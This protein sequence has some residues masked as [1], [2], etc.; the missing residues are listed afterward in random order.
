[1]EAFFLYWVKGL[2]FQ[3]VVLE[4]A[5]RRYGIKILRLPHFQVPWLLGSQLLSEYRANY[6]EFPSISMRDLQDHVRR[7]FGMHWIATGEKAND[8]FTRRFMM[9]ALKQQWDWK[10]GIWYPLYDWNN[11]QV[12]VYMRLNRIAMPPEY[13]FMKDSWGSMRGQ[14]LTV[15]RQHFP[16]DYRRVLEVFP[17]AEAIERNHEFFNKGKFGRKTKIKD[18]AAEV[19]DG[20]DRQS[21]TQERSVQSPSDR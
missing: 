18:G 4:A 14:S 15:L 8:S 6:P 17:F 16:E 3:E 7:K 21:V 1:M 19:R 10:R 2:E 9:R 11:E 5:E 20:A 12:F 13:Q